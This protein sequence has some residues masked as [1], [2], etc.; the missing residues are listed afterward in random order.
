VLPTSIRLLL[1]SISSLHDEDVVHRRDIFLKLADRVAAAVTDLNALEIP[2]E[3]AEVVRFLAVFAERRGFG[4]PDS[5]ALAMD[6]RVVAE[7]IPANL[8]PLACARLWARFRYRRLPE[9]PD[10]AVAVQEE[11]NERRAAA[12]RIRTVALKIR[13]AQMFARFEA[14]AADR[15]ARQKQ[16]ERARKIHADAVSGRNESRKDGPSTVS[17]DQLACAEPRGHLAA[18][19]FVNTVD[20]GH[21]R[22]DP[23]SLE[24]TGPDAADSV[25]G[26][27]P[28]PRRALPYRPRDWALDDARVKAVPVALDSRVEDLGPE[29]PRLNDDHRTG[30][31]GRVDPALRRAA[32]DGVE[33]WR[34]STSTL[35]AMLAMI[36]G[37]SPQ[38]PTDGAV[39][40]LRH[41]SARHFMLT[42][43]REKRTKPHR[44][45]SPP[46]A[47]CSRASRRSTRP[48]RAHPTPAS[49]HRHGPMPWQA[50][51]G[52]LWSPVPLAGPPL[53]NA[54]TVHAPQ[55][56]PHHEIPAVGCPRMALR[57]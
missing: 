9:P 15:Y 5:T 22:L 39:S 3:P 16:E 20:A 28:M 13:T 40:G 45:C 6:A 50:R 44:E 30:R 29:E 46:C 31:C 53:G 57:V 36:D 10:F 52:H 54:R 1:P 2:T 8:F 19:T 34:V 42:L 48:G 51:Q 12:A 18:S 55:A 7:E 24:E 32:G 27:S 17:D 38:Q 49:P 41:N 23:F 11:L 47:N 21:G 14:E 43:H 26:A 25:F 37:H 33:P 4:L 56:A 35:A